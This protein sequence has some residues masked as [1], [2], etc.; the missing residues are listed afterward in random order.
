MDN[1][2]ESDSGFVRRMIRSA[3]EISSGQLYSDTTEIE[4]ISVLHLEDT[5]ED[6]DLIRMTLKREGWKI[7][8]RRVDNEKH[9]LEALNQFN[10]DVIL[11]DY[12]L[13]GYNGIEALQVCS[14]HYPETPFIIVS[15]TLG[16]E[17]AVE[18]LKYGATDYLLKQNLQRLCPAIKQALFETHLK[19]QKI[20]AEEEL[21]RSEEKYRNI[22]E[23]IQD[24]FFQI[25]KAGK[26]MEISPSISR[27]NGHSINELINCRA[28]ILFEDPSIFNHLIEQIKKDGEVWDFEARFTTKSGPL[29]FV[30]INAHLIIGN[31]NEYVG[32]EGSIRD[33]DERKKAEKELIKAKEQA[34]ESDRLKSAFLANI[35]HEI[36]TPMNGI[37]GFAS[38]LKEP[39]LDHKMQQRYIRIIE[40]SGERMLNLINQIIDISKIESGQMKVDLTKVNINIE[41]DK[42]FNFFLPMAQQKGLQFLCKK[43]FTNVHPVILSDQEKVQAVLTNLINNAIKY[44]ETGK[45]EFGYEIHGST[46]EFFVNDTGIGIEPKKLNAIFDRFVQ[47]D[48]S[49][50]KAYEGAGLGLSISKAYIE[51]LGGKIQV[52]SAKGA[53]SRFIFTLPD[54]QER[55]KEV[56]E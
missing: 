21:K 6:S 4:K 19:Q 31:D 35:S 42:L 44:T 41:V 54:A 55:K 30:S 36:R 24:V 43:P 56:S 39:F 7:D 34:E 3:S 8:Y 27:M 11:A 5:P 47:A 23:N 40:E 28:T 38:L 49:V 20:K 2:Q 9:F 29:K 12:H 32:F 37:L 25:D 26:L 33:I 15:G 13:P 18:M 16:E 22:F 10:F 50:S 46:L 45:V 51:M 17:I 52:S 48:T 14:E 1:M 53:G